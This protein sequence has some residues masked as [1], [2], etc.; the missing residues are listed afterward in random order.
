MM[1]KQKWNRKQKHWSSVLALIAFIGGL[2][3]VSDDGLIPVANAEDDLVY[4]PL[5]SPCRIV[6]TQGTA[7]THLMATNSRDFFSYG[8]A[9]TIDAQGGDPAGCDHPRSSEGIQPAAIAANVTAV[10]KQASGNGNITAYPAGS[11]APSASTVNY[12]MGTNI[13]NSTIIGL[14]TSDGSFT[15]MSNTSNVP[16]VIDVVGYFYNAPDRTAALCELYQ[17]LF[18]G[19]MIG[20]LSVPEFCSQPTTYAIGDTGP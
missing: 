16:A 13:A 10:G 8:S 11:V 12:K 5:D 14:R 18:D 6:R 2:A 15:L 17:V 9:G 1:D 7:S 20:A 3:L 19:G 4:V